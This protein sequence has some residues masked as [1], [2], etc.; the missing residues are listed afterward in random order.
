MNQD[1][2]TAKLMTGTLA[3][4]QPVSSPPLLLTQDALGPTVS[5]QKTK[6]QWFY[7]HAAT[8]LSLQQTLYCSQNLKLL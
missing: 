1:R 2:S 6:L 7:S 5:G 8:L 3:E 4:R